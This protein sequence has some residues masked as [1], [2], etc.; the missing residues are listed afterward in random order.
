M[1]L[2]GQQTR[3]EGPQEQE[4]RRRSRRQSKRPRM[5]NQSLKPE[6]TY[7]E[8]ETGQVERAARLT[9]IQPHDLAQKIDQLQRQVTLHK[10]RSESLLREYLVSQ[11][12]P[13]GQPDFIP[14]LRPI[15]GL[16][17]PDI[18]QEAWISLS[19]S[20]RLRQNYVAYG[21]LPD[22]L[23]T[24]LHWQQ[25][26]NPHAIR[27]LDLLG[28]AA[29]QAQGLHN[30]LAVLLQLVGSHL[31]TVSI[32]PKLSATNHFQEK[33]IGYNVCRSYHHW[34]LRTDKDIGLLA[35]KYPL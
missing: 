12:D 4:P 14:P 18:S 34:L 13:F 35:K 28:S 17:S 2:P 3:Q 9:S 29:P 19:D 16:P 32:P 21:V 23:R 11:G 8:G 22:H 26:L 10:N 27:L 15:P 7:Y 25:Q 5:Q 20:E 6:A 31:P 1:S 33:V 30:N 24:V